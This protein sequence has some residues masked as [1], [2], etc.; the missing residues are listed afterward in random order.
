VVSLE[1]ILLL[2]PSIQPNHLCLLDADSAIWRDKFFIAS[3]NGPS[4]EIDK[5]KIHCA[6][7]LLQKHILILKLHFRYLQL[8]DSVIW[9][10]VFRVVVG[11]GVGTEAPLHGDHVQVVFHRTIVLK[12][13]VDTFI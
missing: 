10:G 11:G 3:P 13:R 12:S 7:S 5:S 1:L 2:C 4:A 8:D 6:L 9:D